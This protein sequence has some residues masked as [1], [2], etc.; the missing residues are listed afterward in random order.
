[1]GQKKYFSFKADD[2]TKD[3][4]RWFTGLHAPGVYYGFDF[5]PT[6]NMNLNIVHTSTGFK[7]VDDLEAESDFQGL[8]I[9][10]QGTVVKEDA[11]L[12]INGVANGHAT[13]PRIDIIVLTHT[14][15]E[16][17]G[18]ATAL[19]SIITG[20][21]NASPVA[22][23]LTSA[24]TQIKIAELYIPALTTA[25]N[26]IGVLYTKSDI[27]YFANNNFFDF[28]DNTTGGLNA[29]IQPGVYWIE[30]SATNI[31]TGFTGGQLS[32]GKKIKSV[33]Q[34]IEDFSNSAKWARSSSNSGNT[35]SAWI[36]IKLAEKVI[37]I[38]NWSIDTSNNIAIA[39][40]L[41]ISKIRSISGLIR[42][43]SGTP[44][45]SIGGIGNGTPTKLGIFISAINLTTIV[46][47]ASDDFVPGGSY[48]SVGGFV[49]GWLTI[50]YDPS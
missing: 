38:I 41:T 12:T 14:Y 2:A 17:A 22:P 49:R 5:N 15:I 37:E 46:V 24:E 6:A 32:V 18:G 16:V 10:R 40:G 8:I 35:W 7:D 25:L 43:D 48:S 33:Y 27:P 42:P 9:T 47:R 20:T 50:L 31:P 1:M 4:I 23:T 44:Y 21:P 30:S 3:L 45:S 26:D 13:L 36:L 28:R 34:T 29:I 39:H 19:Y 11:A